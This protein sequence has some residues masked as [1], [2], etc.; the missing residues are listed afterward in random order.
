MLCYNILLFSFF[1]ALF[2]NTFNLSSKQLEKEVVDI[3]YYFVP[4]DLTR[5]IEDVQW[6]FWGRW[7][8]VFTKR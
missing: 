4:C 8:D 1:L 3:Y 5:K 2:L 7:T 6:F